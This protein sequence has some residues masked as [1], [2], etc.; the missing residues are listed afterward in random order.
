[1]GDVDYRDDEA[2]GDLLQVSTD[3]RR[4][5]ARFSSYDGGDRTACVAV[6]DLGVGQVEEVVRQLNDWIEARR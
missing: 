6:T 3:P 5:F 2:E 4:D 1:M